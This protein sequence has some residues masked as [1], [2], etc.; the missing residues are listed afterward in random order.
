MIAMVAFRVRG[1]A[2]RS[3]HLSGAVRVR[4]FYR[5]LFVLMLQALSATPKDIF[6][7]ADTVIT[8]SLVEPLL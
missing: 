1:L 2:S 3:V 8:T 5:L 4:P 7:P 6:A